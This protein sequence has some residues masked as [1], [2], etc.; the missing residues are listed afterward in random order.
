MTD[1]LVGLIGFICGYGVRELIRAQVDVRNIGD[2]IPS[3]FAAIPSKMSSKPSQ[4]PRPAGHY[5]SSPLEITHGQK[6]GATDAAV[7]NALE[8][9]R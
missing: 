1:V 7:M 9:A 4:R 6:A 8:S 2:D 3:D 5:L